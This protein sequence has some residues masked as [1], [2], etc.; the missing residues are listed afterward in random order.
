MNLSCRAALL[1]AAC[2]LALALAPAAF[3]DEGMWLFN[4]PPRDY[5]KKTYQF[6]VED[7]WLDHVQRAWGQADPDFLIVPMYTFLYDIY[8]PK[9]PDLLD[10]VDNVDAVDSGA[11]AIDASATNEAA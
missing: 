10:A 7:K 3:G 9:G 1:L 11:M 2:S 8:P 4:N 6:N 5:L